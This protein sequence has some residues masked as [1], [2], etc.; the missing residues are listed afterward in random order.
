MSG[1]TAVIT[2]GTNFP[3]AIG[4]APLACG[5]LWPI[6]LTDSAGSA[7]LHASAAGA[8]ADLGITKAIKVGTYATLPAGV[9]GLANLSGGD[10]YV[11]N[12][13]VVAWALAN[14]TLTCAHIGVTTGEKFPDA[15]AAGPYLQHLDDDPNDG[16]LFLSPLAGP[17]PQ[18]I[19]NE[20]Y[21]HRADVAKVS[22]I[23]CIEPVISLVKA[24]LP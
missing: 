9:T 23:A 3:D 22:F 7:A 14:T 10:R 4:V 21:A 17:L 24:L 13:N 6:I 2:V 16:L 15:L 12:R 5:K 11:T 19:K 8:L 1:A 18:T 20:I